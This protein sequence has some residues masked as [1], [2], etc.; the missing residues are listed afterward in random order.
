MRRAASRY[1]KPK[2]RAEG[3]IFIPLL[4]VILGIIAGIVQ[5][6]GIEPE[7][8]ADIENV[9]IQ[10]L[11]S[12]LNLSDIFVG[13]V[14]KNGGYMLAIWLTAFIPLGYIAAG[15]ILFIRSMGYG[16]TATALVSVFQKAGFTYA[17]SLGLQG[18]I[19]LA[20]AY[21][22]CVAGLY[23]TDVVKIKRVS[24]NGRKLLAYFVVL[25]IT[26][27]GVILASIL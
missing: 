17:A 9:L 10:G 15:I 12:R 20:A 5:A 7:R 8:L 21:L 16:F 1:V 27:T 4:C 22:L 26:E 25:L 3:R 11:G 13:N 18:I 6:K 19:L 24:L 2:H 23:F 14:L